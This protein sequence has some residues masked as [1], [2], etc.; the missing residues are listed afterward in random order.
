MEKIGERHESD[1]IKN[2]NNFDKMRKKYMQ[3][4]QSLDKKSKE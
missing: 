2:V 1:L 4:N 3:I